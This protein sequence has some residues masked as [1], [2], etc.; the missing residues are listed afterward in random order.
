MSEEKGKYLGETPESNQYVIRDES[1][2][3]HFS[4]IPNLVDDMNLTPFAYRLYG[5]LKR[6][7]G[8][9]GKCWQSTETLAK[10]CGM[11][12]GK[13][14][15]AKKELEN[16]FPP[17]IRIVSK[18]KDDGRTYHEIFISDV[19]K[20]NHD[21]FTKENPVHL[22]KGEA[23]SPGETYPSRGE[24]KNI[25]TDQEEPTTGA[26]IAPIENLPLDWQI[27]LGQDEIKLPTEDQNFMADCEIAVMN[28]CKGA[29]HLEKLAM[30]FVLTRRIFPNKK[31]FSGWRS[32]IQAMYDAKPNKVQPEHI[33]TA[34]QELETW[35]PGSVQDP[36]SIQNKAR[37]FA[38]PMPEHPL[39]E[40]VDVAV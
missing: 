21:L 40:L 7:A 10:S 23:R 2:V 6:V 33:I 39:V 38:N 30:A 22:V 35:K 5:H 36:Y 27:A 1:P 12:T 8:E 19:W 34:I 9:N 24:R 32:A 20:I 37:T 13:V 16:V 18:E 25:P 3:S 29:P 28:I 14:S 4:Q 15:D 11:S 31:Q 26:K 17:L